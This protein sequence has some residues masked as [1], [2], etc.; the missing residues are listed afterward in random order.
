MALEGADD[1]YRTRAVRR[2]IQNMN[3]FL[4]V[5]VGISRLKRTLIVRTT[6]LPLFC[7]ARWCTVSSAESAR[8]SPAGTVAQSFVDS[9]AADEVRSLRADG[10]TGRAATVDSNQIL[11]YFTIYVQSKSVFADVHGRQY[12]TASVQ[13][14]SRRSFES[15]KSRVKIYFWIDDTSKYMSTVNSADT[16]IRWSKNI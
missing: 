11:L 2:T 9:P 10:R 1:V 16:A 15:R 14:F 8:T 4:V 7:I 6:N 12:L 13:R 3:W 5:A